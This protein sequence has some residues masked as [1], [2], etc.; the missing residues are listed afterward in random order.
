MIYVK[1]NGIK[2]GSMSNG[3][4][5]NLQVNNCDEVSEIHI[6]QYQDGPWRILGKVDNSYKENS[7][8]SIE[9]SVQNKKSLNLN[10]VALSMIILVL[11]VMLIYL[12]AFDMKGLPKDVEKFKV[13]AKNEEKKEKIVKDENINKDQIIQPVFEDIVEISDKSV[14]M[15]KGKNSMGTGFLVANNIV[16]TNKHVINKEN[17]D[18]L[19]VFFQATK[20]TKDVNCKPVL[21]FEDDK[22]DIAF[23]RVDSD[24]LPLSVDSD[25]IF[26][27]GQPIFTIGNPGLGNDQGFLKNALS[28]GVISTKTSVNGLEYFQL[29]ISVNPGNSGGPVIDEQGKVVGM[30][31]LKARMAEGVAL[32]IPPDL[33]MFLCAKAK[34]QNG[35]DLE[36]IKEKHNKAI[37]IYNLIE[38]LGIR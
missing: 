22:I 26:K 1:L 28:K 33:I 15:I 14:V 34:R 38:G 23:L 5:I 18:D 10:V 8:Y 36:A 29:G 21:L 12:A 6:S 17:I 4:L 13:E 19:T 35:G 2:M 7:P 20:T 25:Y 11:S 27:K 9:K 30:V 31:T 32:C 24:R 3:E 16:A 37:E